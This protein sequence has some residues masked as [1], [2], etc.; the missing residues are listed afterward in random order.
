MD[1]NRE[2]KRM[3]EPLFVNILANWFTN[4]EDILKIR[5]AISQRDPKQSKSKEIC[6]L[7]QISSFCASKSED[8]LLNRRRCR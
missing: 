5:K 8:S 7:W 2:K 3:L 1:Q 4:K 6:L